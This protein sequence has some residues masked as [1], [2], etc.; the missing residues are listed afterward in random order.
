MKKEGIKLA[1]TNAVLLKKI[2]ELTLYLL[3]QNKE[4][5]ELKERINIL[6]NK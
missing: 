4:I 2:E 5:G 6:E 3:Q 1:E